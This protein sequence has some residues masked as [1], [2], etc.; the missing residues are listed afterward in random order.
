MLVAMQCLECKF[1]DTLKIKGLF[2][3]FD[4]SQYEEGIPD[5]VV[6]GNKDCPKFEEKK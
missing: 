4:C 5:Y 3:Q 6:S 2:E 1:R